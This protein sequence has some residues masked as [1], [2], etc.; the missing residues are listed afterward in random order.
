MTT[1]IKSCLL[2]SL[3]GLS[4]PFPASAKI[5]ELIFEEVSASI[6]IVDILS[7]TGQKT[8]HGSGVVIGTETVVT[9]CH[10]SDEATFLM[11]RWREKVYSATVEYRHPDQD[12]CLLSAPNLPAQKAEIGT[13]P[14]VKI[15]SR[16]FAI[17]APRG[18]ELTMSDGIVSGLRRADD[19][20]VIQTN[21]AISPGSSGGGLFNEDG[22]LIGITTWLMRESQNLNFALAADLIPEMQYKLEIARKQRQK[23][24][25]VKAEREHAAKKRLVE[26]RK[27]LDD[28]KQQLEIEKRKRDEAARIAEEERRL[29]DQRREVNEEILRIQQGVRIAG[30]RGSTESE[31]RNHAPGAQAF[32]T[33]RRVEARNSVKPPYPREALRLGLEGKVR[34]RM[35]VNG[36]GIVCDVTV[37][38]SAP[39]GV[40]DKTATETVRKY[41]FQGDGTEFAVEREFMFRL[42]TIEEPLDTTRQETI[43][44]KGVKEEYIRKIKAKIE[45]NSFVPEG[46]TGNPRVEF[47]IVLLP[48]G[49][50]LSA[51]L[52]KSSGIAAYDEAVER[53]IYKSVPLPLPPNN[54]ELF[55]EFR[56][57]RLPFAYV[58]R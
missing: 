35:A 20:V 1:L 54:P 18:L 7:A 57:L 26:A 15:G 28:A 43:V 3:L 36:K 16:V 45:R 58:R 12:I 29:E 32:N 50:V 4:A 6:V 8:G 37:L 41:V 27:A 5:P 52:V 40:F 17:G 42:Q 22:Q 9:N 34:L 23:E 30:D 13:I 47:K 38:E 46:L 2:L 19:Y 49:E 11:I 31:C 10:V 51:T 44:E 48:T 25:L 14:N 53:S 21:A 55:R 33:I 39:K 24:D 56:E